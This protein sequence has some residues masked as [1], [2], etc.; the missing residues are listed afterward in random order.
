LSR[1]RAIGIFIAMTLGRPFLASLILFLP[2]PALAQDSFA[3]A[4]W[5]FRA[6]SGFD[7]SSGHYGADRPTEI[8]YTPLTLQASKGPWTLKADVAWLRVTGPAIL[9]DGSAEGTAN[10]R[11]SGSASGPGDI[12]LYARYSFEELYGDNLFIDL[13][14]RVKVPT[15][16]FADGLGTGEWDQ[17]LQIDIASAFGKVAP[18]AA[19]GYR[20][21]GE[22]DGFTLR[23]VFYGTVGVQYTWGPRVATGVYYDV[24]QSSIPSGKA[25]QEGAAYVNFKINDR[26]SINAYG[27]VGFSRNSPDAGGGTFITY[28]WAY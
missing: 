14:A 3:D 26:W 27:V 5:R 8:L 9:L 16:D 4:F 25:P 10:V 22:P 24:R 20:I 19:F 13:T 11:T 7:F 1:R 21:T 12:N 28:N 6:T 15:A 2:A 23:N 18:F 17:S